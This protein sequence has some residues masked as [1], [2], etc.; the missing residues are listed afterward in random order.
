MVISIN[1]QIK[2]KVAI[3][4]LKCRQGTSI[5]AL[6]MYAKNFDHNHDTRNNKSLLRLPF[7]KTESAKRSLY[8]QAHFCSNELPTFP[9]LDCDFQIHVERTLFNVR[10]VKVEDNF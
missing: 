9:G 1:N 3:Q 2:M 10:Y 5:P 6:K 8:F 4:M 7:V